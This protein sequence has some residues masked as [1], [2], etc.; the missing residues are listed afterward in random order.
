M[1]ALSVPEAAA[2]IVTL[3]NSRAASP[4]P[5]EIEAIIARAAVPAMLGEVSPAMAAA[6][7]EWEAV[8][9]PYEAAGNKYGRTNDEADD[10]EAQRWADVFG[11]KSEALLALGARSFADLRLLVPV[12]AYWN[13]PMSVDS[14]DYP[15]C[16]FEI[17][18]EDEGDGLEDKSR[19]YFIRAV[20]DLLGMNGATLPRAL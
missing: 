4:R 18:G 5:D 6:F 11:E 3:I 19:A 2:A 12:V 13:S 20:M 16:A 15:H 14:P 7:A 17:G 8:R 9:A 10:L 1:S